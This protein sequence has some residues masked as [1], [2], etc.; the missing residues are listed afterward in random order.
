METYKRINANRKIGTD[1]K[2]Q[3][4]EGKSFMW[5]LAVYCVD[6][7]TH[8]SHKHEHWNSLYPRV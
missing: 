7:N 2:M 1:V 6:S 8:K 4:R 3:T 5:T